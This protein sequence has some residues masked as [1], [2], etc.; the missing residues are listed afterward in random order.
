M[1]GER[2]QDTAG[3]ADSPGGVH[4]H[5]RMRLTLIR[6][7][8]QGDIA[9]V[10]SINEAAFE[11]S[12][13]ADIVDALRERC[14][15][16]LS[17]VSLSGDELVGHILFSPVEAGSG[18]GRVKG[19]G[20]APMAVHP[21]HQRQGFGS[22]LVKKGLELLQQAGYPFVVVLGHPEYYPRFGFE[23]ASAYG[24]TCEISGVPDEAFMIALFDENVTAALSGT[25]KFRPELSGS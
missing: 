10:R 8:L 9:L 14:G 7:E 1:R 19:M 16:C 23:K 18:T 3:V 22:A 2:Q 12:A 25:V 21:A 15:E 20:L 24:L 17:L 5:C 11:R 4:T 13:E 6:K